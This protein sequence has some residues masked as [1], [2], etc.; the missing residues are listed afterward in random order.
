MLF[1]VYIEKTG[2]KRKSDSLSTTSSDTNVKKK[3]VTGKN[4][5]KLQR[6]NEILNDKNDE[7]INEIENKYDDEEIPSTQKTVTFDEDVDD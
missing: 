5:L 6:D 4:R 3:A 1:C 7:N 2:S